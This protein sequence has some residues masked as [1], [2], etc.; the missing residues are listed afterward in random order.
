MDTTLSKEISF[1]RTIERVGKSESVDAQCLAHPNVSPLSISIRPSGRPSE[2]NGVGVPAWCT[3]SIQPADPLPRQHH[4][5]RHS[6]TTSEA[7]D[8][9][10]RPST[11]SDAPPT[12]SDAP[13]TLL[14]GDSTGS[15]SSSA[16]NGG[17]A[18]ALRGDAFSVNGRGMTHRT[19]D[20]ESNL[21]KFDSNLHQLQPL[22]L[23]PS[24]LW[25]GELVVESF[26]V[27][28]IRCWL[29]NI[30]LQCE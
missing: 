15:S 5:R 23:R 1:S 11:L 24:C 13:A 6:P 2:V 19:S 30:L 4:P 25:L 22:F 26:D 10:R 18:R 16:Y 20:W 21:Q 3:C 9:L 28:C 17:D 8:D 14:N 12:L 27:G 29:Q 7:S